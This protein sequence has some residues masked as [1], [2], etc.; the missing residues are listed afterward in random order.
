MLLYDNVPIYCRYYHIENNSSKVGSTY[1][2]NNNN[3][4]NISKVP[5]NII[6]L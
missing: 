1:Y 2:N 4:E 3:N 6:I 5:H